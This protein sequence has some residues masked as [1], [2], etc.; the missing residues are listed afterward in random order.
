MIWSCDEGGGARP[1]LGL[2]EKKTEWILSRSLTEDELEREYFIEMACNTLF[3]AGK[4]GFINP[5][6]PARKFLIRKCKPV[7]KVSLRVLLE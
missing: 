1:L 6:D 2:S 5:P 4:D 7:V 3:G